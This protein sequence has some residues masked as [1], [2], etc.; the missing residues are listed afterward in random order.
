MAQRVFI[1]YGR[2]D[3]Y[4]TPVPIEE[5]HTYHHDPARSFTR[6][7]YNALITAGF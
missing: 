7:L 3:D 4:L 2:N 1:S 5:E 6:Q